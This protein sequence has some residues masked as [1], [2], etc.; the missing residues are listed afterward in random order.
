YM[1]T[2]HTK[3]YAEAEKLIAKALQLDSGD[4]AI[5]DSMGW[6]QFRL[7]NSDQASKLLQQ[8]YDK[9]PDPEVAAHLGEVLWTL[10]EKAQAQAIWNKALKDSPDQPVLKETVDRLSK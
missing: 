3:R 4:A 8:A 5:L 7:G 2:V 1:L 6:V 9:F 10:G